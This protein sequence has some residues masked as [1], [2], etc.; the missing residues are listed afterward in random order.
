[1]RNVLFRIRQKSARV[2]DAR[3][4]RRYLFAALETTRVPRRIPRPLSIL[5]A[6]PGDEMIRIP[7]RACALAFALILAA[8]AAAQQYPAEPGSGVADMAY[9]ID[10]AHADSIRA[11]LGALRASPGVEV[12]VLTVRNI[13]RYGTGDATPESFAT[14]VYNDWKLGYDQAQDGVLVMVSVD[15]RFARIELGDNV[16]AYQDARMQAI[17]DER[18]VPRLRDGDY[19]GGVLEGVTAIA[20]AFRDSSAQAAAPQPV[21]GFSQAQPAYDSGDRQP[22]GGGP[23]GALILTLTGLGAAG[24]GG[25]SYLRH[26]KRKCTHCGLQMQRLDEKGDDVYLD[27]G[28]RLEEVLGSVDY[29]VWHCGGCGNHQVLSYGSFLSSMATCPSCSYKTVEVVK[30]VLEH[31]TY[32]SQGRQRITKRCKHCSWHDEDIVTLPRLQRSSSG[33]RSLSGGGSSRGGG[34]GWSGGGGGGGSSSG[35]GAS[36]RW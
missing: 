5:S 18:M 30:H 20:Q 4:V 33:S 13:A 19:S 3:R 34:G 31:P 12:R 24:I 8:P 21:G 28:R 1:V 35:R 2:L 27:S 10:P 17:M 23:I 29:D 9:L 36:G 7:V 26:R 32:T 11:L 25:A 14:G 16:P 22:D 6:L 15:D